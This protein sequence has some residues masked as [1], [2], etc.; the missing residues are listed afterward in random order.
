MGQN[1]RTG[2][3]NVWPS[4]PVISEMP[5]L[6]A[7]FLYYQHMKPIL[8]KPAPPL[9]GVFRQSAITKMTVGSVASFYGFTEKGTLLLQIQLKSAFL[10]GTPYFSI[11][12]L[13]NSFLHEQLLWHSV[14]IFSYIEK[15]TLFS[16]TFGSDPKSVV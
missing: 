15:C 1:A 12:C 8:T 13:I 14:L 3:L 7:M 11:Y 16:P 9:H 2:S 5:I 6:L 4:S 10:K